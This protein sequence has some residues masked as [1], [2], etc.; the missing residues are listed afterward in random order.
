MFSSSSKNIYVIDGSHLS[1]K[2]SKILNDDLIK[3]IDKIKLK[4]N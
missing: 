4:T 3:L 2:G 1:K